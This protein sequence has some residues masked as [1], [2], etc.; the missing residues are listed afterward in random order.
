MPNYWQNLPL[1]HFTLSQ[2][3]GEIV[4]MSLEKNYQASPAEK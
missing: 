4:L 2:R 1:L 3:L